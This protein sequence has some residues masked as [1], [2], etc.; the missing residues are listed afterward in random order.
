[1]KVLHNEPE[2]MCRILSFI[3]INSGKAE[4]VFVS[5]NNI[6][7]MAVE[8]VSFRDAVGNVDVSFFFLNHALR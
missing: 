6:L 4:G 5:R 2:I 8:T 7:D 3:I 1:M